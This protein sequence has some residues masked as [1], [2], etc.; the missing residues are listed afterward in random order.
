MTGTGDALVA[1]DVG[2]SGARAVAFDLDGRRLHEVRRPYPT[3]SPRPGWAEQSASDWRSSSMA[4]LAEVVR[5]TGTAR[6][7][8][9]ISLTGQCPSVVLVDARGR[10]VGPGLTYRD[11]R[12]MAEADGIR[13]RF[14]DAAMHARTGHRPAAFHIAPKLL[15]LRRH[16]PTAWRSAS[17]ALQPR[18][19]V[20][21]GLTGEVA[22]DGTHAAA[23]LVYNLRARRW[24][25][26]LLATLD[27]SPTLFP[28]IGRPADVVGTLRPSI[29]ARLGL[30]AGTPVVLG[31]ADSQACAFGAG[32][33]G[34]GPVSEM[35]GS[36]TCLNAVV[37]APL[38]VLEVTH[39]PHVI[40][41]DFT[42]ETGLN[43]TGST[44]VWVADRLYG[45][46]RGHATAADYERLNTETSAARPGADGLLFIPVLGDGERNDPAVRGAITG[47][48]LR[49]DRAAVA[50]AALEGVA[51]AIRAQLELLVAGGTQV[52]ELRV[53]GGD[54]RLGTWNQVKA[55]VTG[56]AVRTYPGDATTSGVAMLAGLG[57]GIYRDPADAIARC[58]RPGPPVTPQPEAV[59]RYQV[60]YERFRALAASAV[61]RRGES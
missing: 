38:D 53:S 51:Y 17:L 19:W 54:A 18:D 26:E 60:L 7:V 34:P 43:T 55:D 44:V 31:G 6:K 5:R 10:A 4:S 12:A 23:T 59:A 33:V 14:G 8:R 42:T 37:A 16:D 13:A 45:G 47:L 50:R 57:V 41:D 39:Y 9:A 3:S 2:T 48:S 15:W 49:H 30:P 21:L 27:L 29:A 52:T 22:T 56:L 24:D 20:L 25:D 35:A 40:G 11:N 46:R 58:V 32:V 61:V 1:I 28:R 36:S